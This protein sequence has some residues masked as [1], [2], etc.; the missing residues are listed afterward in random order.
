MK[1]P[2]TRKLVLPLLFILIS[3]YLGHRLVN[4]WIEKNTFECSQP[5]GGVIRFTISSGRN[6]ARLY[7]WRGT[8]FRQ[9]G[10]TPIGR[11]LVAPYPEG[12]YYNPYYWGTEVQGINRKT[13]DAGSILS[14]PYAVSPDRQRFVAAVGQEFN[15]SEIIEFL[16]IDNSKIFGSVN[17]HKAINS[18]AW[19][20][21]SH[22][23]V[24]LFHSERYGLNPLSLFGA[25]FGHPVPYSNISL[26]IIEPT[27]A[28]VC[29]IHPAHALPYGGGY[30]RWDVN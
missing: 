5:P 9:V 24:V 19:D 8:V 14:T 21:Q 28:T 10:T 18:I 30:V 29:T 26:K 22:F 6:D 16:E 27:G 23:V 12:S 20:P 7:E 15:Y 3:I 11:Q 13:E 17:L 25:L 1:I 4:A 2:T